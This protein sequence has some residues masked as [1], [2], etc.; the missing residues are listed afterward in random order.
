[1]PEIDY[2]RWIL[3]YPELRLGDSDQRKRAWQRF[4]RTEEGRPY[5]INAYEGR[6]SP[7]HHGVLVRR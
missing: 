2:W 7:T 5:V 6:K 4:L 3:K 1:M